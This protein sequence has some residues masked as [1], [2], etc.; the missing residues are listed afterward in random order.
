M[1]RVAVTGAVAE[2][3]KAFTVVKKLKLE[4]T[5]YK[6]YKNTAFIQV[7]IIY[8]LMLALFDWFES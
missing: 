5:P 7:S 8:S 4:G 1:F 2:L 6:I 3:D